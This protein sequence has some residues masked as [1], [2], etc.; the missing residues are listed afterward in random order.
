[1]RIYLGTYGSHL[2]QTTL[3]D[4][5]TLAE[6]R[7]AGDVKNGTYL[8][9]HPDMPI[10]YSVSEAGGDGGVAAFEIDESTGDLKPMGEAQPTGG[11]GTC[12]VHLAA[13][14]QLLL[15]ANY[16]GGSVAAFQLDAEG[17]IGERVFFDQHEGSG[18]NEQRQK[19]PHAH[20]IR[21]SPDGRLGLSCNLGADKV[22]VYEIV[23]QTLRPFEPATIDITPGAGPRHIAFS[24]DG[25]FLYV[26]GELDNTVSVLAWNDG[27]ATPVQIVPTLPDGFDKF[28]KSAEIAISNDGRFLYASNRG[29]D[30]IAI[31]R[32]DADSGKLEVAGHAPCGGEHPR[33]FAI[34]P[35]GRRMIVA[36][37]DSNNVVVFDLCPQSGELTSI[38]GAQI[39][40]EK[41]VC[42][43]I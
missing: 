35:D 6:A 8:A 39:S 2:Y 42:V 32:R 26:L 24:D 30:S 7:V 38:D 18:P 29:H 27:Q 33:H 12:H 4:D 15:A 17:A 3:H 1:M 13:D 20:N 11:G 10:V 43:L 40:I 31:F 5:G 37:M 34:T 23:G 19:G 16:G 14:N 41:P 28:S 22:Y 9:K 36:N 21:T 25:R